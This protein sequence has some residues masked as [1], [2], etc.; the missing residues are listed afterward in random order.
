VAKIHWNVQWCT[1]L[2]GEPTAPAPTVG[3]AISGRRVA[4]ANGHQVAP[5]C[6]VCTG[7]CTVCQRD[8]GL[9][10]WLRYRRKE[11]GHCSCPMVHRTVQCANR[12]KALAFACA[13]VLTCVRDF[14]TTLAFVY[15][16]LPPLLLW[17]SLR[18]IL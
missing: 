10:S 16:S 14:A 2:S 13:R 1:G 18:S 15:V 6:P 17:F 9:N 11:I 4:K 12:Q 8:Q 7:Q 3:S 5:D